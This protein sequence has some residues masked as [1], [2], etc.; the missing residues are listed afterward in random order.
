MNDEI[1]VKEFIPDSLERPKA[2]LYKDAIVFVGMHYDE[3]PSNPLEDCDGMGSIT[4]ASTRHLNH[5]DVLGILEH[6]PDAVPLS[7]FEHSQCQW[8]VASAPKGMFGGDWR[9]DGVDLAGA[10]EP[11]PALL[12]EAK[13]LTG[14][15]RKEMMTKWAAE[16]CEQFTNFCNGEVYGYTVDAYVARYS[17]KGALFD[18]DDDYRYDDPIGGD[19][20]WGFY[21]Y[22]EYFAREV[23]GAVSSVLAEIDK[24]EA[25]VSVKD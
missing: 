2:T 9:W 13:D 14:D 6:N 19:S 22:D 3:S 5:G 11:D 20:C 23:E 18:R 21:G 16:A 8:M 17:A 12:D 24:K 1:D 10:W 25:A 7:Y 15:A 4:S